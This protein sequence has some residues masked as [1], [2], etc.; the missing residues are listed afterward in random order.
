MPTDKALLLCFSPFLLFVSC[1]EQQLPEPTWLSSAISPFSPDFDVRFD[2]TFTGKLDTINAGCNINVLTFGEDGI[3]YFYERMGTGPIWKKYLVLPLDTLRIPSR[4]PPD[5]DLDV[6]WGLVQSLPL[7]IT[8]AD[9]KLKRMG[10]VRVITTSGDFVYRSGQQRF[11]FAL[12][13]K[14]SPNNQF[15][16][17]ELVFFN[18]TKFPYW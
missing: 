13:F 1:E 18:K 16:V 11:K 7:N 5:L 8:S 2:S 4:H 12:S 10:L 14:E 9:T 6:K 17:R 15:I 3:Q